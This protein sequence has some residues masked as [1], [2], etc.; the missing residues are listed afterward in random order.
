LNKTNKT[1]THKI[2]LAAVMTTVAVVV[3]YFV[4][5][6]IPIFG[7]P[8]LRISF[9][10]PFLQFI[11]VTAGPLFGG[12]A[13][14]TR[15]LVSF[16][17]RGEGGF[18]W[19]LMVV[20]FLCGVSIG[21]LWLYLRNVKI[22][23]RLFSILFGGVFFALFLG[24]G[25]INLLLHEAGVLTEILGGVSPTSGIVDVATWGLISTGVA[26]LAVMVL[27]HVLFHFV[28]KNAE[29]K[30]EKMQRVFKLLIA[31]AI[32]TMLVTL[33]NSFILYW[34]MAAPPQILVYFTITR[35]IRRVFTVFYDVYVLAALLTIAQKAF[36]KTS[37]LLAQHK[38][39]C[40]NSHK[41]CSQN[42]TPTGNNDYQQHPQPH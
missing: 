42:D 8:G 31:I 37:V 30:E 5:T 11:S 25:L 34:W 6:T 19:P 7:I 18:I 12:M 3:A 17:L 15:D 4:N 10:G 26:G 24:L 38:Q 2:A 23:V 13:Y 28:Y 27:C 32:P 33:V 16:M 41:Q 20:D 35:L 9:H 14:A 21:V 39:S 29:D 22:N 40:A 1:L 36:G